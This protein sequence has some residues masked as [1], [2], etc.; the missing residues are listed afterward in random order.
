MKAG[1]DEFIKT[2]LAAN[3]NEPRMLFQ[4]L[5]AELE[6]AI[7]EKL[8]GKAGE[9]AIA[10]GKEVQVQLKPLVQATA[11]AMGVLPRAGID[12]A[13]LS[14]FQGIELFVEPEGQGLRHGGGA[15]QA[16]GRLTGRRGARVWRRRVRWRSG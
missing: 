6:I 13:L 11:A 10:A 1:R 16:V 12:A 2:F 15:P 7:E 3:P 9:A 5:R 4:K 8:Q 14:R